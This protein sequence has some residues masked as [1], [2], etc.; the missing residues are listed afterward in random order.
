[1]GSVR[2]APPVAG[3]DTS[4]RAVRAAP[5][6]AGEFHTDIAALRVS[7]CAPLAFMPHANLQV[8]VLSQEA[9][10]TCDLR[11]HLGGQ[12]LICQCVTFWYNW[13]PLGLGHLYHS[14]LKG[15]QLIVNQE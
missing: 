5:P 7:R 3:G 15:L 12:L 14:L 11:R 2:T 10:G 4:M 13:K 8:A 9:T 1:M 6:V